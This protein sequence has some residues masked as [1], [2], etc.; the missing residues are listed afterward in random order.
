MEWQ[1]WV[2][3]YGVNPRRGLEIYD[4]AYQDGERHRP[5]LYRASLAEMITPYGDPKWMSWYPSD[6]GDLNLVNYSLMSAVIGEDAPP[7]VVF[8]GAISHDHLG[9]V[10]EYDRAV[11]LFERD[12]GILWRHWN[13]AR[14]ARELVLSSYFAVDNYD[15]AL[16][17]IF[18]Q[19]GTIEVEVLL[20]GIINAYDTERLSEADPSVDG[21]TASRVLVAP[22]VEG[23]IHQ[24]FFS[25]RAGPRRGRLCKQCGGNEF[26]DGTD[27]HG[28]P[29]GR[30]VR[31][32]SDGVQP[33]GRCKALDQCGDCPLVDGGERSRDD[34]P[35]APPGIRARAWEEQLL[36]GGAGFAGAPQDAVHKPSSVGD[37]FP[38][39]GDVSGGRVSW[40]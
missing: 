20:S 26:G 36:A 10:V 2:F 17:W 31:D 1:N 11:S 34:E 23:P 14:R 25:Y 19:D 5:V 24:H 12:G 33:G 32:P 4:V 30:V 22:R 6:E 8:D 16:S 27:R 15:Y 39:R 40:S 3:H 18:H 9:A 29:D 7:N 38:A 13:E 28:K 37:A 21:R 35:G